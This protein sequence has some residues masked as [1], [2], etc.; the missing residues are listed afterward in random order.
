MNASSRL[1]RVGEALRRRQN[2]RTYRQELIANVY[3]ARVDLLRKFLDPR[4][5]INDECGYPTDPVGADIYQELYEREAVAA[6]VVQLWPRESWQVQPLIYEDEDVNVTTA[7]EKA[8]N[9]LPSQLGG[10]VSYYRQ[11]KGSPIWEITQRVDE[12]SGIGQY[13]VLLLGID[14]G[15]SFDMPLDGFAEEDYN[16]SGFPQGVTPYSANMGTFAQYYSPSYPQNPGPN[17]NPTT[18]KA[19]RSS[20]PIPKGPPKKLLFLRAFPEAL[21][22]V[23]SYEV[24]PTSPRFGHPTM[25]Q[26]TFN[27]PRQEYTGV[28]L[29]LASLLV[30]WSRV[31]HVADN[32]DSSEVF[33]TPR[34]RPVLNRLLD[35]RKLY[36]GSAEMYWR[37]AFPG[38]SLES[39]PQMGPD[40]EI[41]ESATQDQ[42]ENYMN[43]LQRYLMFMG[44][45]V[46]SLA[47]QVVDP[48]KQIDVQLQAI[49]IQLGVPKR[50]FMGTERGEL[51]SGQDDAAWND[52]L[53]LRQGRYLTP[54]VIVPLID[55]L[56]AANV[57]PRPKSY[58]V[59]WPDLT[60]QS[61]E[62]KA[63]VAFQLTQAA[64][65]YVS[66]GVESII[67]PL[68]WLTTIVKL[69]EKDAQAIVARAK[70]ATD[71]Q[72]TVTPGMN[73]PKTSPA[74]PADSMASTSAGEPI[75]TNKTFTQTRTNGKGQP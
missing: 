33:G 17:G 18:V 61:A 24:R 27:D 31:V 64:S 70:D 60:S 29:P 42:M 21:V 6:R 36:S 41:D 63:Q 37:G 52:R 10:A 56:I 75:P 16:P 66:T 51:A 38:L 34:M 32:L 73:T 65:Q 2:K 30:H 7:F 53:R 54:R 47:P 72:Q 50:I 58:C 3:S 19:T 44:M 5:N 43:G 26:I 9:D 15:K 68:D 46:K 23:V 8:W 49:C 45:S 13:G 11:E 59:E 71:G 28:G 35:L 69:D 62:E 55:R 4:R 48:S 22:Q 1:D 39:M 40:V 14:D 74:N 20:P 57:L 12:L 25:Y 67:S